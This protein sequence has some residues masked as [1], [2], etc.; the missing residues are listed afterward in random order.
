M[1]VKFNKYK[2]CESIKDIICDC[3][4]KSCKVDD[5]VF[6]FIEIEKHWGYYSKKDLQKWTAQICENC[7]DEKLIFIKFKKESI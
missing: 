7:V 1:K 2:K 4:G 6:E 5:D 3:C